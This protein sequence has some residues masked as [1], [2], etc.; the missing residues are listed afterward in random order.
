MFIKSVVS[1]AFKVVKRFIQKRDHD[2]YP[3]IIEE[4][5]RQFYIAELGAT[6]WNEMKVKADQMWE[7]NTGRAGLDQYAGRYF[8]D[9]LAAYM[10]TTPGVQVNLIGHSAGSIAI[11][12]LLK[13]SSQAHSDL[14]FNNII[15]MA[16]AC[17]ADI[18]KAEIIDHTERFNKFR[19]F[20][21]SDINEKN[22]ILVSGLY[23]Q[24]LLYLISGI[25]EQGG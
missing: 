15:F 23:T 22:D 25:L 9:K 1:I 16:P 14:K 17:R 13:H 5:L 21:M 6:V 7:D 3:T 19:S 8:L 12:N 18:F 11:C 4:I 10:K 24:S 2:F 20:T